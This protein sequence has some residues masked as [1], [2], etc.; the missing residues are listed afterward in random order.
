MR[1]FT[2]IQIE[3]LSNRQVRKEYSQLRSIANKRLQRLQAAG[4]GGRGD[5]RFPVMKGRDINQIAADLADVSRF[6]RDPRTTVKGENKFVEH[7]LKELH[8][9]GYSWVD[10]SNFYDFTR[11]MEDMRAKYEGKYFD[12]GQALDVYNEGQ[13]LNIPSD[14]LKRNFDY[15]AENIKAMEKVQPIKTNKTIKFWDIKRKMRRYNDI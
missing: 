9:R 13:R 2:P 4:L 11:F 1:L 5:Y 3:Q 7:E 10:R 8:E 6:L 15:F 12:S 14:V